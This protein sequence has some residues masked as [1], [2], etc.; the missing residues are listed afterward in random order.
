MFGVAEYIY[1]N[2]MMLQSGACC[3]FG[4]TCARKFRTIN[5]WLKLTKIHGTS[6]CGLW[7]PL[8]AVLFLVLKLDALYCAKYGHGCEVPEPMETL[9]SL[10]AWGYCFAGGFTLVGSYLSII[11]F[12]HMMRATHHVLT[13]IA[14]PN[15]SFAPSFLQ[16]R[17]RPVR[18]RPMR[19][20]GGFPWVGAVMQLW[21]EFALLGILTTFVYGSVPTYVALTRLLFCGHTMQYVVAQKP[22][23]NSAGVQN[24]AADVNAGITASLLDRGS[25]SPHESTPAA[26]SGLDGSRL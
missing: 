17:D 23:S 21:V 16:D 25:S 18:R 5:F 13:N 9:F 7:A 19:V 22:T 11:V 15:G 26:R 14:D 1:L 20:G 2:E 4:S 8:G 24:I 10:A 3:F 6:V 12:V